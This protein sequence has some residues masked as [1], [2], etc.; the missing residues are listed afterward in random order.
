M[1][2]WFKTIFKKQKKQEQQIDVKD[3]ELGTHLRLYFKDP[4]SIGIINSD[5]TLRYD[6]DDIQKKFITGALT[7][8]K[9]V[10]D[11]IF[12]ELA[13]YKYLNG[14]RRERVYTLLN[15]E[16]EKIEIL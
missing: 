7:N 3:I 10:R 13:T 16:I 4:R 5:M 15:E 1:I 2:N 12:L 11:I 8:R 6:P 14:E 9:N